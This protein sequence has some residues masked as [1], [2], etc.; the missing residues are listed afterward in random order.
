LFYSLTIL[1]IAIT[2]LL[3]PI[4]TILWTHAP[5][6][7]FLQFPWRFIAILAAVL[8]L[9]IALA[10]T[11]L[12]LKPISTAALTFVIAAAF[13]YPAYTVFH[14]TCDEED[15]AQ[16]RLALFQSNHGT[17]PTDEYTP[18]TAD[19]DSLAP[20]DPPF[21]LS[22]DPNAKAPTNA[23]PGAVPTH[24]TVSAPAPEDLILNLRDYPAW[25]LALNGRPITDRLPRDDGL[26]ALHLPAGPST[27][28][29]HYAQTLDQT[30]G[31]ILSLASLALLALF[32]SRD[33]T[34]SQNKIV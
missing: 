21:W 9:T 23:Q 15:T 4:T 20:T 8:S 2:L 16:A 14:Q 32:L 26:I 30:L 27:I 12:K 10:F 11:P 28:D 7:V 22:P 25:R 33:R 1:T 13:T 5:E 31:D 34:K 19:N 29:I 17:E 3:T 24:L 6:L 18:V